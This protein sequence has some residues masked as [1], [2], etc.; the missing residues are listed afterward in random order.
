MSLNAALIVSSSNSEESLI[1]PVLVPAVGNEP[2]RGSAFD[3]PSDDLDGVSSEG[4]SGS[5]VID[6]TLVGGEVTVD[7]EGS[8][9]WSVGHD[10]GLDLGD[11]GG[12]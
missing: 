2:V 7:G 3:S 1:S 8:L 4:G 12:D 6:S 5:V 9:N 11:L 10:F